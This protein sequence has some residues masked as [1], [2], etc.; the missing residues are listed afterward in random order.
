[1]NEQIIKTILSKFDALTYEISYLEERMKWMHEE[2][3]LILRFI[4][5]LKKEKEKK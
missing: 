4:S 1:M 3:Q 2:I 5:E